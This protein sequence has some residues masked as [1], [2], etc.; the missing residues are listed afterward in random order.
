MQRLPETQHE[1]CPFTRCVAIR[2]LVIESCGFEMG[3]KLGVY[4]EAACRKKGRERSSRGPEVRRS[5]RAAV[6]A[7]P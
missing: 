1:S 3:I 5:A 6:G 7:S 4:N 2:H